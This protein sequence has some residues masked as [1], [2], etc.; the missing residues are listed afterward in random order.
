VYIN[1]T[2]INAD[3]SDIITELRSQLAAKGI[4][5]LQST[6]DLPQDI[7]VSCPYH[8]EGQEKR[9]S[10]GM[11]K[12]DGQ[13]HCFACQTTRP[14][15]CVISHCFG[16]VDD[17]TGSFGWQW[18]LKNFAVVSVEE[19]KGLELD[20]SRTPKKHKQE[21]VT[22]QELDK[23]R[24]YHPY[25]IGRGISHEVIDLFDVGYDSHSNS[26]TFPVRDIQGRCLFVARRSTQ[27]KFFNFPKG[28]EKTLYG[29]YELS[30]LKKYPDEVIV[31]EGYIDALTCWSR[32]KYAVALGGLGNAHQFK[33]LRELESRKLIL[34]TDNDEAGQRARDRIRRNVTNKLITEYRLPNGRKDI[35]DLTQEEFENLQETF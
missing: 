19:R 14:L 29:I 22:E 21:F 12:S 4:P 16:K 11:R 33:Q 7:M 27:Y 20:I 26:I 8:K 15:Q 28:V 17:I 24:Y 10:S 35:N 23:Y 6:R 1:E 34:G 18:L 9:P 13:F 5:L 32:G 31:C 30:L 3:L 2:W 25:I